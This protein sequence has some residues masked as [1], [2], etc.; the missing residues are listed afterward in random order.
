M[1]KLRKSD[2]EQKY[3]IHKIEQQ[4]K[5][6]K[7][8]Q[9]KRRRINIKK[10]GYNDNQQSNKNT[11]NNIHFA[12]FKRCCRKIMIYPSRQLVQVKKQK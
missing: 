8:L 10:T 6:T 7:P 9:K 5:Y 11:C 12:T 2:D 4:G 1:I 3:Y